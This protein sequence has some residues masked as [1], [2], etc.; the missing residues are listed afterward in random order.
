VINELIN[1][2]K[3]IAEFDKDPLEMT[4]NE[5]E[6]LCESMTIKYI[7]SE[8][9]HKKTLSDADNV[10]SVPMEENVSIE[11]KSGSEGEVYEL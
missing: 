2:R 8:V 6:L 10:E 1:T 4:E 5:V 3:E 9:K 11:K 7:P